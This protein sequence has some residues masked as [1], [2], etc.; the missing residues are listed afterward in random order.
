MFCINCGVKLAD[1]EKNCPLCGTEVYHPHLQRPNAPSLYPSGRRPKRQANSVALNGIYIIILLIPM[2]LCFFSDLMPDKDLDWFG[3]VAGGLLV[4]YIALALPLWFRHPNPVI[5]VPCNF[6]TATAYLLYVNFATG[7]RW[8]LTLAFPLS[9]TLCIIASTAVTLLHYLKRGRLYVWGGTMIALGAL[10]LLIEWLIS[11][12]FSIGMIFW[13]LYPLIT[14]A[15][16]GGALL[17]LAINKSA[18]DAL[19]QKLF[20]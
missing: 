2:L 9:L 14:L 1:T 17:Y 19:H 4:A 7:G 20:F 16:I 6:A 12:T 11:H 13:S 5:F 10:M 18:R 8:F 3:L 15:L